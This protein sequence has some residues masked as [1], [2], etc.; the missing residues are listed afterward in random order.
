MLN[1]LNSNI[2]IAKSTTDDVLKEYAVSLYPKRMMP[3]PTSK[4]GIMP[5][6]RKVSLPWECLFTNWALGLNGR[7]IGRL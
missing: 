2:Q 6:Y 1:R 3:E 4:C 5:I 7:A